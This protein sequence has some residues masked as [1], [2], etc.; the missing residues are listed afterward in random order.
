M[1]LHTHMGGMKDLQRALMLYGA[2]GKKAAKD[3]V[4]IGWYEFCRSARARTPSPTNRFGRRT[5]R[6]RRLIPAKQMF[7]GPMNARYAAELGARYWIEILS[8]KKPTEYAQTDDRKDPRRKIK[9]AGL[10]AQSWMWLLRGSGRTYR[11]KQKP[12]SGAVFAR[13]A[14]KDANPYVLLINRINYISKVV[15]PE[16]VSEAGSAAG[17]SMEKRMSASVARIAKALRF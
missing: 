7:S 14:R 3:V 5:K 10:A 1:Q 4:T 8:Q 17:R 6:L 11:T 16:I 15:G 9:R 2:E 12:I 13:D